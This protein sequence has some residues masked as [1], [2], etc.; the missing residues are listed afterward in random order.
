MVD[1]AGGAPRKI[2]DKNI[3]QM[4]ALENGVAVI[5]GY[6]PANEG[7]VWLYT[8]V[9][10]SN[11]TIQKKADLNGY[12]KVVGRGD[13]RILLVYG[14]G[15]SVVDSDFNNRL[16]SRLP[17]INVQPNSV[18]QDATG[19]IYVGMNAFVVRLVPGRAGYSQEWFTQR[20]CLQ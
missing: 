8:K 13:N 1:T 10:G 11:S 4:I 15:V 2:L 12:P 16:I 3:L 5:T 18:A 7:S 6:L 14:N 20:A 19:S 17:I 9:N